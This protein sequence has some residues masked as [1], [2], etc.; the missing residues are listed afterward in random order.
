VL[1]NC[2]DPGGDAN[3]D[4]T[5]DPADLAALLRELT[6]GDG[7]AVADAG[8]GDLSAPGG[9]VNGDWLLTAADLEAILEFLFAAP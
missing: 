1:T 6:D 4:G 2:G 3:L 5:T 7:T 9:D 8:G